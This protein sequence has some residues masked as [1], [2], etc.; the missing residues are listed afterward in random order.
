MRAAMDKW[1]RIPLRSMLGAFL[2]AGLLLFAT[3]DAAAAAFTS[4]SVG[5]QN[6]SVTYGA[7]G[8]VTYQIVVT[9]TGGG[10]NPQTCDFGGVAGL[11][12]D[13][14]ASFDPDP[15]DRR[16]SGDATSILTLTTSA[17][18]PAGAFSFTV[19]CTPNNSA[20]ISGN[21]TLTVNQRPITATADAKSKL[22]GAPDPAL[23][24]QVTSGS[25]VNG[26]T[27]SGA[28]TRTAGEAA[29]TYPIL[30]GTLALS[31][32]YALT[33]V[34]AD[35]TIFNPISPGFNAFESS[36]AAGAISG[37]IYTKLAGTGFSLD[38]VAIQNGA[39]ATSFTDTAIVE[40]VGNQ[41]SG[42]ALDAQN[43]PTSSTLIQTV[44]PNPTIASGRSTVNFAAVSSAWRDVRVRIRFPAGSPTVI[45]C[46]NDNFSIR[47]TALSVTS[48]DATNTGTSG[49]PA[50]KTGANFSLTATAIAGYNGT[51][52]INSSKVTGTPAAGTVGG[53]FTAAA[54]ATGIATGS[55]FYYSEVGNFGLLVYAVYDSSFTGVDAPGVDCRTGTEAE[56]FSN[57]LAG[58]RYGC[59]FGS[60]AVVQNTGVSGFGRFIPDN[61][62]V[63][64]NAPEFG[65]ACGTFTYVG[66]PFIYNTAPVM[67][68]AARS[69]T[70]NGLSNT[71]TV[72]YAGAYAKLTNTTLTP[73]TQA[74]RYTRFDALA[75]PAGNTPALDTTGLPAIVVDPAVDVFVNGVTTLTFNSGAGLLFAR[76]TT[77]KAPFDADIALAVNVIDADGVG[78]AG[79]PAR[80]GAAAAGNGIVFSGG[81]KAVRFG[82]LKLTN[83]YGSELLNLPIPIGTEYWNATS[84][85]PNLQDGC[86]S[87]AAGN[88]TLGGYLGGINASNM[89]SAN[90][91]IGGTFNAGKG[92]LVLTK[93][94]PR[95]TTKGSA[96]ITI[97]LATENKTYLR[98]GPTFSSD[99][100][101]R[102]T[103]GI[104]KR[105]PIIYLR[106][107]Y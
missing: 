86:T 44:S 46:S 36:T 72:N 12:S 15:V 2:A 21:G 93:P 11:P 75:P 58:G 14:T 42:V 60:V 99:P 13:V 23:T 7:A 97:D 69:G 17:T 66:Q 10:N 9:S 102:A 30:Q 51:P 43:C 19:S 77:A 22:V 38:V 82:R 94:V 28:L 107:M 24:Y 68:I 87:I 76:G 57:T 100:T 92:S 55:S 103:F 89:S 83:A 47:P 52:V 31:A 85:V 39:Q 27:F 62:N 95:P 26:D 18:T 50:I 33:Y 8:S 78:F 104:Y 81:N 3:D 64:Y 71:T 106:E 41:N 5:G 34:S 4:L 63:S 80:F 48:T 65:A 53:A 70:N 40:L 88:V 1:G 79:N 29:G 25:L 37:K 45:S 56:S 98:T 20:I 32:N 54:V 59:S 101:A 74:A 61:F 49:T 16:G 90:V 84:F 6:G 91:S 73:N 67:T 105:G 96:D 35:L